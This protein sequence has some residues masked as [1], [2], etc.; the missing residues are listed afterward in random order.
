MR[1]QRSLN[2]QSQLTLDPIHPHDPEVGIA[3]CAELRY[4]PSVQRLDI[5]AEKLSGQGGP[6]PLHVLFIRHAHIHLFRI[7]LGDRIDVIQVRFLR[8]ESAHSQVHFHSHRVAHDHGD[9]TAYPGG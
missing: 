8:S 6:V 2:A 4:L 1:R 3:L 7:A 9:I 5:C